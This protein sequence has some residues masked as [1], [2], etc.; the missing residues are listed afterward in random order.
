MRGAGRLDD[1]SSD[2]A[3]TEPA[4]RGSADV[5][6]NGRKALRFGDGGVTWQAAGGATAV[7][8]NGKPALRSGDDTAHVQ[9][10]GALQ[11]GSPDVLIGNG[12][13]GGRLRPVLRFQ[14]LTRGGVPMANQHVE[15][16]DHSGS[17][18][19]RF[20]LD[21]SGV[22]HLEADVKWGTYTVRLPDGRMLGVAR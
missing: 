5:F 10:G 16:L 2:G 7:F 15:I 12:G 8:I 17:V 9:G 6:I 18:V 3:N 19:G 4:S 1:C 21:G 11:G 13:G 20:L 14:V 22:L